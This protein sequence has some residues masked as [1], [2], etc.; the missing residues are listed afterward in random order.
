MLG[1][2]SDGQYNRRRLTVSSEF[3][4]S[5]DRITTQHQSK[6]TLLRSSSN[7]SIHQSIST[8]DDAA[9]LKA[10]IKM[11]RQ[12]GDLMAQCINILEKELFPTQ[13]YQSSSS[14]TSSSAAM[15]KDITASDTRPINKY[16]NMNNIKNLET[17][18][19]AMETNSS[20]LESID[21]TTVENDISKDVP[22][23]LNDE[24]TGMDEASIIFTLAGL[25]H[26]RDVLQGKQL[27]F[28]SN[29]LDYQSISKHSSKIINNKNE[30]N[31]NKDGNSNSN[32]DNNT[33][34]KTSENDWTI[35]DTIPK[36]ASTDIQQSQKLQKSQQ[37]IS[38][39][40]H[41]SLDQAVS[42]S[43][44]LSSYISSSPPA[45]KQHV[46][47][48]IDDLLSD[49]EYQQ[50]KNE[51]TKASHHSVANKFKWMIDNDNNDSNETTNVLDTTKSTN[52][53]S[54]SGSHALFDDIS[55]NSLVPTSQHLRQINRK[56]SSLILNKNTLQNNATSS[57]STSV[58][59]IDPL[60][61]KNIDKRYFYEYD[62]YH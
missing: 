55:N 46:T 27:Q 60:D 31:E 47:Y 59:Q 29:I 50:K 16:E 10:M 42:P 23:S 22:N 52:T 56:R 8:K 33:N 44:P 24:K 28:D 34:N 57:S 1:R 7:S 12:M 19:T 26:I 14:S 51:N 49:P 6:T 40:T 35:I 54:S 21:T 3:P 25:K 61:A 43:S 20:T 17:T 62:M 13:S 37:Q 2:S 38:I 48:S 4:D 36:K 15:K 30:N 58:S 11:N 53:L 18:T 39:T 5:I 45:S 41:S 9:T 32:I